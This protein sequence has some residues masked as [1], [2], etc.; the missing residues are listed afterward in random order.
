MAARPPRIFGL[1]TSDLADLPPESTERLI[2]ELQGTSTDTQTA[3]RQ[4]V[5]DVDAAETR[6]D[7]LEAAESGGG[8]NTPE[9]VAKRTTNVGHN[10]FGNGAFTRVD[11]D[12]VQVDTDSIVTTGGT[13][14]K[15]VIPTTGTYAVEFSVPLVMGSYSYDVCPSLYVNGVER[16][17]SR[18]R[19]SGTASNINAGNIVF[20]GS[21]SFR[22]TAG[23]EVS[24]YVYQANS[25]AATLSMS[26]IAQG[27]CTFSL[28]RVS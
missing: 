16:D 7:A 4:L 18:W 2:R 22:L 19:F 23:D 6:L 24:L 12:V 25:G 11:F 8:I 20:S 15:A 10:S 26:S 5:D 1:R 28:R 17:D 21:R 27:A 9:V 3:I 13:T 14:W